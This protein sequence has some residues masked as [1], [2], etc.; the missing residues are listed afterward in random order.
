FLQ[1]WSVWLQ[2]IIIV[3]ERGMAKNRKGKQPT[4]Q[5]QRSSGSGT[6]PAPTKA[7]QRAEQRRC[8]GALSQDEQRSNLKNFPVGGLGQSRNE[9]LRSLNEELTTV[10]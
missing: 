2:T 7:A 9:E 10:N 4:A 8:P 5:G 3:S 1:F 6:L